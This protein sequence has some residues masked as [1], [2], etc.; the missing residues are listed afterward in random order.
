MDILPT[1]ECKSPTETFE[2]LGS[3][4]N[5]LERPDIEILFDDI[6]FQGETFQRPYQ[7]LK[8]LDSKAPLDDVDPTKPEDNH[9][10][11]LQVLLR[12]LNSFLPLYAIDPFCNWKLVV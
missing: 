10:K 12:Y 1:I 4:K 8:R 5:L 3:E 11:C 6:E 7:Y 9:M 2:I